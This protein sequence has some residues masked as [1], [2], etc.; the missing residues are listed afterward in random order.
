MWVLLIVVATACMADIKAGLAS[1]PRNAHAERRALREKRRQHYMHEVKAEKQAYYR[2]REEAKATMRQ[3][4][5]GCLSIIMDGED[6]GETQF[7]HQPRTPDSIEKVQRLKVKV[8]G[9]LIHGL[10]LLFYVMPPWLGSGA[11]MA[12]T[13]LVHSLWLAKQ[14]LGKLPDKL[15]LQSDNGSKN[16][17]RAIRPL[18]PVL[19]GALPHLLIS[20]MVLVDTRSHP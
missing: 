11:P 8:Q 18:P 14:E 6:Q 7:P 15:Y 5:G 3:E 17:N 1:L 9:V 12:A 2:R 10:V 13:T 19:A 16:K 20:G 4:F